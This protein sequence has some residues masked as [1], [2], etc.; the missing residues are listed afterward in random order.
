M[1]S[2]PQAEEKRHSSGLR[3]AVQ[4]PRPVAPPPP[5][6]PSKPELELELLDQDWDDDSIATLVDAMAI[7]P[8]ENM[9]SPL[10]DEPVPLPFAQRYAQ[11]VA[12]EYAQKLDDAQDKKEEE[13]AASAE[14]AADEEDP[15]DDPPTRE[16]PMALATAL[17]AVATEMPV[18]FD[19]LPKPA[20]ELGPVPLVPPPPRMPSA[21]KDA[22][23]EDDPLVPRYPASAPIPAD[24]PSQRK[25]DSHIRPSPP[26]AAPVATPSGSFSPISE[27]K[28]LSS[29]GL[30]SSPGVLPEH[31]PLPSR[32]GAFRENAPTSQPS[33]STNLSLTGERSLPSSAN[34]RVAHEARPFPSDTLRKML[35]AYRPEMPPREWLYVIVPVAVAVGIAIGLA[36]V[37]VRIIHN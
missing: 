34:L 3:P 24:P 10:G 25:F 26:R 23:P 15:D 16:T 1:R 5:P 17:R 14:S 9:P 32:S 11:Q 8:D 19:E 21:V 31:T 6:E 33:I 37:F 36:I 35:L 4:A 7:A 28:I 2:A 27:R 18:P 29:P 30:R 12:D 13:R 22:M 20:E